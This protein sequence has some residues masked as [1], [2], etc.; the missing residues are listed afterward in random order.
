MFGAYLEKNSVLL[1]LELMG[2]GSLEHVLGGR[3]T[4]FSHPMLAG[5]AFQLSK[6]L[7]YLHTKRIIHR[8]IK[9]ENCL[10]NAD[11]FV[12]LGDFGLASLGDRSMHSTTVGTTYFMSP[13]R[14]RAKEYGAPSDIWSLGLVL[15]HLATDNRPWGSVSSIV[16]LLV[17]V[18]EALLE[19]L[20]PPSLESGIKDILAGCLQLT[21]QKRMP[22]CILHKSPWF[23]HH[24]I[25]NQQQ[26]ANSI[27]EHES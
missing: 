26:A 2:R 5:V 7:A 8:D 1:V 4:P 16:D 10:M 27:L 3:K 17:T 22:A 25:T 20:I 14:L 6:G 18:E 15:I 9:T 21:P 11:G 23:K 13:E 12:K 24:G 19:D